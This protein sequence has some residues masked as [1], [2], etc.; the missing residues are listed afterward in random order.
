MNPH[1]SAHRRCPMLFPTFAALALLLASTQASADRERRVER[2]NGA[3]VLRGVERGG[4]QAAREVEKVRANGNTVL[5][6][7]YRGD[8]S[9][10]RSVTRTNA[11]GQS[12]H[13]GSSGTRSIDREAGTATS[14]RVYT[15][16]R[17]ETASRDTTVTRT[18]TG[19][20]AT[21]TT[22][23]PQGQTVT[24]TRDVTRVDGTV[25][26]E[27]SRSGPQGTASASR[28]TVK[29]EDGRV[30]TRSYTGVGGQTRSATTTVTRDGG[31]P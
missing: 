31:E 25:S 22:T 12:I 17:G 6:E 5:K 27:R 28:E 11:E 26:V 3:E 8:G 10:S 2:A 30:S 7:R 20:S 15:G 1:P 21:R 23:G 9:F 29:T 19:S 16:P 13:Y 24:Q 18:D 14:S 4:G